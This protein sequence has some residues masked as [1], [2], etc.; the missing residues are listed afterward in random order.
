DP[1]AELRTRAPLP[2]SRQR[3]ETVP[4]DFVHE[5]ETEGGAEREGRRTRHVLN[6]IPRTFDAQRRSYATRAVT[7]L[8]EELPGALARWR[9]HPRSQFGPSPCRLRRRWGHT[10]TTDEPAAPRRARWQP[11]T[12]CRAAVSDGRDSARELPPRPERP[13][14]RPVPSP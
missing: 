14:T 11:T 2:P 12:G 6:D 1:V 10:P 13:R 8:P 9:N 4:V 5:G 3:S 7:A